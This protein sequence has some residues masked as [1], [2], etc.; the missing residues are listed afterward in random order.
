M[1][2]NISTDTE[3]GKSEGPNTGCIE[4][5]NFNFVWF[6][7]ARDPRYSAISAAF[8]A[9]SMANKGRQKNVRRLISQTQE[10]ENEWADMASVH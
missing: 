7:V 10:V 4:G 2:K 6:L 1:E 5:E 9:A 3:E 8:V